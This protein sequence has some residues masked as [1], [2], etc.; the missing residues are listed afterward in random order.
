MFSEFWNDLRYRLRA[1]LRRDVAERDLDD[2]LRFHIAREAEKYVAQGLAHDEARRRA[3]TAFGGLD[4]IK[5]DTRDARGTRLFEDMGQDLRYAV[6]QLR[7]SPGFTAMTIITL[8]LGIGAT[9]LI[10]AYRR[11]VASEGMTLPAADRLV[12]LGQGPETCAW[13]ITMSPANYL[14]V[15]DQA[16]TFQQV[17][18]FADWEPALRGAHH[19]DLADGVRVTPQFFQTLEVG[20][21]IGRVLVPDDAT[22][23]SNEVIVLS[24]GAWRRRFGGDPAVVG[25]T[26]VLDRVPYTVVGVVPN[27]AVFPRDAE[28]WTPLVLAPEEMSDRDGAQYKVVGR[29]RESVSIQTARTEVAGIAARVAAELPDIMRGTTF[30]TVSLPELYRRGPDVRTYAAGL[31]LLIA[32]VNLAGLL[33]AR[34]SARRHE[35]AIRGALGATAERMVRQLLAE[36][37]LLAALAGVCGAGAAAWGIRMLIDWPGMRLDGH[38]WALATAMGLLSGI[39]VGLWPSLRFARPTFVH[40]LH[41]VTRTATGSIGVARGR[42][43]LVVAEV[44]LAIVL[45]SAAGLLARSYREI[46]NV[47]AGFDTENVLAI[48]VRVPPPE[49]GRALEPDRIDRLVDAIESIPGVTRA[50]AV[51]GIPFGHGAGRGAFEIE[52]RP[53]LPNERPQARMQAATPGYFEALGIPVVRGRDFTSTDRASTLPVAVVNQAFAERFLSGEDPIGRAVIIDSARWD[54]V[55]VTGTAF[56]GDQENLTRP[57]PEIYR[58]QQWHRPLVWIAARTRVDPLQLGQAVTA[59]VRQFDA[60]IPVT[61]LVTMDELRAA[62]MGSE[63]LM[64]RV[65]AA[66]AIAAVLISAIGLYGVISFSV[67]QRTREFGV[68]LALGAGRAS[69]LRLVL[70]QGIRLTAIGVVLGIA[71]AFGAVRVIRSMLFGVSASDPLTLGAVV[72]SIFAVALVAAYLPARRATLVDPITSLRDG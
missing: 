34:H 67:T 45:L 16:R 70:G 26:V 3:R 54:I 42:R 19:T 2:E 52:G 56:D 12:Y 53:L 33:V 8:A 39:I 9:T 30:L 22:P 66:F 43:V 57:E 13:C 25:G 48:R 4:Q 63:R 62:S 37:V 72:L 27:D 11:Y 17:S 18:M 40:E 46:Y 32:C 10:D 68:R 60:D 31:V 7:A 14:T 5:E 15:R 29:L 23:G 61:R 28:L 41:D 65:I 51:L 44:A 55:G 50:G 64:L 1:I 71:G 21:L 35:L 69:V 20:P 59:A 38:A 24:E 36:V 49:N 6:R 47:D 58:V